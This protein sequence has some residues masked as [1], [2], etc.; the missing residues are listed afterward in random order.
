MAKYGGVSK[1]LIAQIRI[2]V[3]I[4]FTDKLIWNKTEHYDVAKNGWR[5][6]DYIFP[7]E[8]LFG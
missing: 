7:Q 2:Q 8:R 1:L 4:R 3:F 5:I 6:Y